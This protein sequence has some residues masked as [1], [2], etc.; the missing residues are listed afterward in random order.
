MTI[1]KFF[2]LVCII[3]FIN[4]CLFSKFTF[5]MNING[6]CT[7]D[8]W[9]YSKSYSYKKPMNKAMPMHIIYVLRKSQL[10]FQNLTC[11]CNIWFLNKIVLVPKLNNLSTA[12]SDNRTEISIVLK[13]VHR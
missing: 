12:V 7:F 8:K 9:L 3:M 5:T 6:N 10:Y 1:Y 13:I 11:I 4:F 2:N